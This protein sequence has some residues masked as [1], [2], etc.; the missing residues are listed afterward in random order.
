P[1]LIQAFQTLKKKL[2]EA[3]IL[4]AP[5]WDLADFANYHAGNFIVNGKIIVVI[6]VRDRCP[7]RKVSGLMTHLVTSLT[8]DS[9]NSYVM[10]GASCTQKKVSMVLFDLPS[11]LMLVVIVV[12]VMIVVVISVVVV[13]AIVGVVVGV[14]GSSVSSINKLLLVIVGYNGK[15]WNL[16]D[17]Y[18]NNG[19]SDP[20]RGLDTK[21]HQSVV[22]L[23]GDE[24]PSNEDRGTGMGDSIGVSVS[25]GEISLEGNKSWESNISDSDNTR[26]G[27]KIAG[28]L[29]IF[30][31]ERIN[32]IKGYRGGSG[33]GGTLKDQ[34]KDVALF[35][36]KEWFRDACN[37]LV[38]KLVAFTFTLDVNLSWS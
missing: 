16:R 13:F 5:N 3:P 10:Q 31:E 8:P 23:T 27:G 15:F 18:E 28:S 14:V 37:L 20:I 25:L 12:T 30:F 34:G 9:A 4:I 11:I 17:R 6:L 35:R 36:D 2:T 26:D 38:D 21:I 22:D 29:M 33:G 7:R 24:V 32:A 19:M 1:I